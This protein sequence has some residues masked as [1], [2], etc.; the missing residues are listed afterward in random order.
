MAKKNKQN[1]HPDNVAAPQSCILAFE[2]RSPSPPILPNLPGIHG[3]TMQNKPNFLIPKSTTTSC[4]PKTYKN[5]PPRPAQK[6][7]PKQTQFQRAWQ[8][9]RQASVSGAKHLWRR[10]GH[11]K[12]DIAAPSLDR[13]EMKILFE[14]QLRQRTR[15]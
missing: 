4:V 7:K 13:P 2:F 3:L 9:A 6:N 15:R 11:F 14:S 1:S 12:Y 5:I 8:L 10:M